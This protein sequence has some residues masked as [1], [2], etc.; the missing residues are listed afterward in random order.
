MG[1]GAWC[2]EEQRAAVVLRMMLW[3]EPKPGHCSTWPW[4]TFDPVVPELLLT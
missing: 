4:P 2:A 3:G 1:K